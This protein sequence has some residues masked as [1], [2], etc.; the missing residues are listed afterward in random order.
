MSTAAV[1]PR[2][3]ERSGGDRMRAAAAPLNLHVAGIAVLL[4]LNL[5][6]LAHLFLLWGKLS[7]NDANALAQAKIA[8]RAAEVSVQPLKGLDAKLA[9]ATVG[10]DGFYAIRLPQS[11]SQVLSELGTLTKEHAVRLT[12]AQYLDAPVLAGTSGEMTEMHIDASLSGD[13]RALM[14]VINALERDRMFFLIDGISL[15]GQQTGVVNL[16]LRLRTYLRGHAG[17]QAGDGAGALPAA[18]DTSEGAQP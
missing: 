12:R 18:A 2:P 16:R 3:A 10:A 1:H 14:Q 7:S 9:D 13:Y 8:L 4:G 11:D 17:G 6:L 15:S 5:Y